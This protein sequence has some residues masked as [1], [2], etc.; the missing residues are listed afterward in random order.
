MEIF[1]KGVF[2]KVPDLL[3][4]KNILVS[5]EKYFSVK[6]E[7]HCEIIC[8]ICW[9]ISDLSGDKKE[10]NQNHLKHMFC[11][12]TMPSQ[13]HEMLQTDSLLK[14]FSTTTFGSIIGDSC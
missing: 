10:V 8:L 14:C 7:S 6:S 13:K 5:L 3:R 4:N 9:N 1:I 11:R 12:F 2:G